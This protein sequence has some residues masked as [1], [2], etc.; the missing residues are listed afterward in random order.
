MTCHAGRRDACCGLL[1]LVDSDAELCDVGDYLMPHEVAD[2]DGAALAFLQMEGHVLRLVLMV[3]DA[4]AEGKALVVG[5][6][7]ADG[8]A[9]VE[10]GR[11]ETLLDG[12]HDVPIAEVCRRTKSYE[13]RA[14][15]VPL[16]LREV[17]LHGVAPVPTL[18]GQR[19]V[20][21]KHRASRAGRQRQCNQ[22]TD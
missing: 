22:G 16:G 10:E 4:G 11:R 19:L 9:P 6:K 12:K 2:A 21:M 20:A 18:R 13:Q 8:V 17:E 1:L 14:V 3:V 5:Q 15:D 7:I